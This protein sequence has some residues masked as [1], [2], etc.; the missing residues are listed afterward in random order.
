[1]TKMELSA[2]LVT[3]FGLVVSDADDSTQN[4][5]HGVECINEILTGPFGA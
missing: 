4:I 2:S 1:M 5:M 3:D